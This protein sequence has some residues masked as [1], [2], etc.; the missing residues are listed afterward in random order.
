[1]IHLQIEVF[2]IYRPQIKSQI[3]MSR[4]HLDAAVSYT[5]AFKK[6]YTHIFEDLYCKK[7]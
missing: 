7:F 5:L 3:Y 4:G 2:I 6:L 1:M